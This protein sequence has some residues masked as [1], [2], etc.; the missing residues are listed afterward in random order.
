MD[1]ESGKELLEILRDLNQIGKTVVVVTHNPEVAAEAT[2]T[3][4]MRD[5]M[6]IR[7]SRPKEAH[8]EMVSSASSPTGHNRPL[9]LVALA[10]QY[11]EAFRLAANSIAANKLRSVLTIL[12]VFIGT[13]SVVINIAVAQAGRASIEK[14]TGKLFTNSLKITRGV[15]WRD[16]RA[17]SILTMTGLDLQALKQ[18]SFVTGVS[19]TVDTHLRIRQ[20]HK[21]INGYVV[22]AD[23]NGVAISNFHIGTGQDLSTDDIADSR[24]VA[25]IDSNAKENLFGDDDPI[26]MPVLIGETPF[27]VIGVTDNRVDENQ[28]AQAWVPYSALLKRVLGRTHFDGLR[29]YMVPEISPP[30]AEQQVTELLER[31]HGKKDFFVENYAASWQEVSKVTLIASLVLGLVATISLVVGGIGVMNIMLVTVAERTQEIG[32]RVAIGARPA[33]ITRQF[34]IEAVTLCIA[35]GIAGVLLAAAVCLGISLMTDKL[36]PSIS[37]L[38]TFAAFGVCSIIGVVFGLLPARRAARLDPILA[39]ARE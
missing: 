20:G 8:N 13:A 35:G 9:G 18:L 5:G 2:R 10:H 12:G 29:V 14:S 3:I 4:E 17:N 16:K 22:G 11:G 21:D 30:E 23:A 26:G 24:N 36:Q 15:D 28:Q 34:L 38:A 1:S 37:L 32:I 39:L 6:I 7:D 19:P 33:D 25:V 31:T 27:T